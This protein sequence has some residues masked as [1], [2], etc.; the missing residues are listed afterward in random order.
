MDKHALKSVAEKAAQMYIDDGT[1]PTV[2][3]EKKAEKLDLTDEQT[4]RVAHY[5]NQSINATLMEKNAYT[6][7]PLADPAKIERSASAPEK[8]AFVPDV[9]GAEEKTAS[10]ET[11]TLP[12][13]GGLFS[14]IASLY[15][16]NYVP[17]PD[18]ERN[19]REMLKAAEI[20]AKEALQ[21]LKAHQRKLAESREEMYEEVKKSLYEGSDVKEVIGGLKER[22]TD[23]DVVEYILNR[24]EADGMVPT[25]TYEDDGP[26]SQERR[27]LKHGRT[28]KEDSPLARAADE[29]ETYRKHAALDANSAI[30]SVQVAEHAPK[31]A[32]VGQ[33]SSLHEKQAGVFGSIGRGIKNLFKG[34][35][36]GA[37]KTVETAEDAAKGVGKWVGE[38]PLLRSIELGAG[39]YA[40]GNFMGK[41]KNDMTEPKQQFA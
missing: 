16:A 29:V 37:K 34:V 8:V 39:G 18:P 13:S 26:Y 21:D 2:A 7:F 32:G 11:E 36:R 24:L 33:D 28:L 22:G 41:Q 17:S 19:G 23:K 6:D 1:D 3:V 20:V 25:S 4:E 12:T 15:G 27:Y 30:L 31:I 10:D 40:A 14:K 5:T 35:G 38:D 9:S